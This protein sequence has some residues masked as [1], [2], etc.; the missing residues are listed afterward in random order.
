MSLADVSGQDPACPRGRVG[1]RTRHV[2]RGPVGARTRRGRKGQVGRCGDEVVLAAGSSRGSAARR[3]LHDAPSSERLPAC[4]QPRS[5]TS[6]SRRG[7][8]RSPRASTRRSSVSSA[9]RRRRSA[10]PSSGSGSAT[11]AP[12]LRADRGRAA[13]VP[14]SRH[15]GRRLRG[16]LR[17]ADG[18]RAPRLGLARADPRAAERRG[19]D[20]PARPRRQ[21]RRDRLAGRRHARPLDRHRP[22]QACRPAAPGGGRRASVPAS[23]RRPE[24]WR[25]SSSSARSTR[26][27]SSTPSC[28]TGC[29]ST[30]STSL[31]VDAGIIGE[32]LVEPDVGREEVAARG[33]RGRGRAGGRRRPRRR[34]RGDG[35]RRGRDR[36]AA[37]RRGAARRDRRA[38]RLGRLRA[39]HAGDAR[40]AG[41][42]AEAD[43]LDASPRATRGPTSGATDVT[44]MYSVVDIAGINRISARIL[45]NA[46]GA[47]AGMAKA[48]VPAARRRP[49]AGR[50]D[51]VR[52]HDA[53]RDAR[54]R[55]ARGA[56]LRGAR[57]PRDRHRRAVDGGA[58]PRRLPRG[59]ARRRRRR[60]SPTSS[61]AASSR[62]GPDRLEAAGDARP[63]AGRLARRARH[64]Q[65]RAARDRAGGVPRAEPLRAQP[66]RDADADDAGGVRR[67]RAPDR[68]ASSTRRRA[69]R[70]SSCRCRASR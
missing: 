70:R 29:A 48:T 17:P 64:G 50:G 46:A 24:P 9:C 65:L 6:A 41:R 66:D 22:G 69:R 23:P 45:A 28:A 3:P 44:M 20:V 68:R 33:R 2:P 52:R 31:L 38:R 11:A 53:V 32:P 67:A 5:T 26:R 63:A 1:A 15:G 57:L 18:A 51:D 19:A 21:P 30:A 54:P 43:G 27:G 40:A 36:A 16:V 35:A 34:D 55:A 56:R 8:S 10:I 37:A 12:P 49:A 62:P 13:A 60:S 59:R 42:R 14:P 61:S 25:R 7:T 4:A 47:I 58:G 39:R